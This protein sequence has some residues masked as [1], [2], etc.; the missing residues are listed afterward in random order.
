MRQCFHNSIFII[1]TGVISVL[2]IGGCALSSSISRLSSTPALFLT[3]TPGPSA[4]ATLTETPTA[5]ATATATS[6]PTE[7]ATP[8]PCTETAGT[9]EKLSVASNALGVALP[10]SIY[11]PPCYNP[12][13]NYPV[14]YLLHGQGMD[15]TYWSSLG[16]TG[17][18]DLAIYKGQTPFIMVFPF[19]ERF[20]EDNSIS[21][22]PEAIINDLIPWVDSNYATCTQKECR[23]IGGISRGGGWAIKLFGTLGG[24]SY[25]LMF[26][27]SNWVQKQL[28]THTIEDFPR[29]YLDRGDQDSLAPDIDYYVKV[30]L[31]NGIRPEF[32]IYPGGHTRNYW[33][34]HVQEYM[35]FY[36]D[37]WPE[38]IPQP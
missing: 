8:L 13:G 3:F 25:G 30:L 35:D 15:D 37:A 4:T 27:D 31:A 33:R 11:L 6:T 38:P 17:I 2:T 26:G 29:I 1:I 5:T 20:L 18:A 16:V 22:F 23:A 24:H 14:L 36:M 19:E 21:K 32:H 28:E 34:S 12:A 10:V 9:V 7:T